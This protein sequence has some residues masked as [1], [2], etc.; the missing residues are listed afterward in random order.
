[1]ITPGSEMK[2][3]PVNLPEALT[4]SQTYEPPEPQAGQVPCFNC[5]VPVSVM[6][7]FFG[8]VYCSKSA[9]TVGTDC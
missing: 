4:N 1:M 5:G 6:L 9:I 3:E 7:P 8:C 2:T